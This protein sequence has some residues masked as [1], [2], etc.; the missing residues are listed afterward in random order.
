MEK[1][2]QMKMIFSGGAKVENE[3]DV[4]VIDVWEMTRERVLESVSGEVEVSLPG[5]EGMAV[6]A[7]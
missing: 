4:E 3:Y 1:L 2:L 6:L 5:K 7:L